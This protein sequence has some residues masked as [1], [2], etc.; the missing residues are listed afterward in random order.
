VSYSRRVRR[1]GTQELNPFPTYF[2]ADNVF[3]G[4]P[5]LR[6]EYT[7]AYEAGLTKTGAKGMLQLSPFYRRTTNIIRID[8]NPADTLD[9]REVTSISYRNL[10]TGNS[11]GSDLTGQLRL[12]PRF[13]AL[14]N[15]SLFKQVTDGGSTSALGSDAI[16]WQGRINVTSQLTKTFA[17]QAAY[18]YRAAMKM[19]RGEQG[20]Q[21]MATVLL[22]QKVQG[23]KGA[24][25]LRVVD[26]FELMRFRIRA[27]DGH[28]VQLTERNP[29]SR[30]VFL[31]Y[32]YTF[33]RPPKVRQVAPEQGG[34][35][36]PFGGPPG[37]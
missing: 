21:Q 35:S 32:Q 16:G 28:V 23:D 2:D 18:N 1:P 20:A 27:A 3:L 19:E 7:D 10:A 4:S 25:M 30:A 22:R 15:F 34:G 33:G 12:S 14:S 31:G 24:L 17:V 26:P 36:V 13:T 11:W 8:I 5:D 29:A 9:G 37:A 6:P